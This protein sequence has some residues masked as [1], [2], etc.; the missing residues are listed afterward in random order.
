MAAVVAVLVGNIVVG[1]ALIDRLGVEEEDIVLFLEHSMVAGQEE[2]DKV[3]FVDLLMVAVVRR[4]AMVLVAPRDHPH[5]Y[6]CVHHL[7]HVDFD[8]VVFLL[9]ALPAILALVFLFEN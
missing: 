1:A 4:L 3:H 2:A 5:R 7:A 8:V 9:H 6:G